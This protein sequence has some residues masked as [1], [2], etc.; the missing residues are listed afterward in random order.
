MAEAYPLI[1]CV[2][3]VSL[4]GW[5]DF[6]RR[7]EERGGGIVAVRAEDC[8]VH[9]VAAYLPIVSLKHGKALRV[10]SIAAF[11]FGHS[12]PV[13]EALSIALDD[14]ARAQ[15]CKAVL[16]G[17]D[18]SGHLRPPSDLL[19]SWEALGLT[20]ETIEFVRPLACRRPAAKPASKRPARSRRRSPPAR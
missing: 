4:E 2:S 1:R 3:A 6:G 20:A 9:G 15:G 13:R 8:K 7:L 18:A 16:I 14:L 17:L 19:R 12:A 10:D 5:Q 11:E